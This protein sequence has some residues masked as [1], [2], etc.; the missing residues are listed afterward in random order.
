LHKQHNHIGSGAGSSIRQQCPVKAR[1]VKEKALIMDLLKAAVK[2]GKGKTQF[3]IT[4]LGRKAD[5][6]MT[7]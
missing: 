2:V 7:T 5:Q 1:R 6:S 3:I 4:M